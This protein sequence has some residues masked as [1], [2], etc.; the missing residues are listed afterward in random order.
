M[1]EEINSISETDGQTR[2][3]KRERRM[4]EIRYFAVLLLIVFAL[5]LLAWGAYDYTYV[6]R[7]RLPG[8]TTIVDEKAVRT[9]AALFD[10]FFPPTGR[11]GIHGGGTPA[12]KPPNKYVLKLQPY[13]TYRHYVIPEGATEI[14]SFA[15]KDNK[16]MRTVRLSDTVTKIN[17]GA[18]M[19]CPELRK[20][21]MSDSVTEIAQYAFPNCARLE[22]IRLPDSLKIIGSS[23]FA[24]CSNLREIEIPE[25]VEKLGLGAFSGTGI[26]RARIS[27]GARPLKINNSVF[28]HCLELREAE[29]S[30]RV[31]ELN[32]GMFYE[33]AS[34]EKV[35]LHD[36]VR[37]IQPAFGGCTNLKE[38]N[39]PPSVEFIADEAFKGCVGLTRIDLSSCRRVSVSD[40]SFSGCTGLEQVMLPDN[41]EYIGDA[42]FLGCVN[43]REIN[44]PPSVNHI[45]AAFQDCSSLTEIVLDL[46]D[47]L[48][49]Y[50]FLHPKMFSGCTSLTRLELP[51]AMTDYSWSVPE[52]FCFGCANLKRIELPDRCISIGPHAFDG[53]TALE[54]VV[55]PKTVH[56]IH[57]GAFS[58][59]ASLKKIV[60][61]SGL[62]D[63][64]STTLTGI[65]PL[66]TIEE[67]TFSGCASLEE[68]VLPDTLT[69]I[70]DHAFENCTSLKKIVI[71]P[72]VK[73]IGPR[74]FA[75]CTSLAD[76]EFPPPRKISGIEVPSFV[77]IAPDAF[78]G[79]LVPPEK[80]P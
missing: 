52:R 56:T 16:L 57:E 14:G 74:A 1:T 67:N 35:V 46:Q 40:E 18:F 12:P 33:C 19:R 44:I 13:L 42:A 62:L 78:E 79:T 76:V 70:R 31:S 45:G 30:G 32:W 47:S 4:R 49:F 20:V 26:L 73:E 36:G 59:C 53:C 58:G 55:M 65:D 64:S 23:A 6:C 22:D 24:G 5:A 28:A 77:K 71:P 51:A 69:T 21:V 11:T 50:G 48:S 54:E 39:F 29:I 43:L 34:L 7:I 38:I 8:G 27:D 61:L 68:V 60:L 63:G 75:G 9:H 10:Y 37:V 15:F 66:T 3:E 17:V 25:G 80:I 2:E 41:T 72:N